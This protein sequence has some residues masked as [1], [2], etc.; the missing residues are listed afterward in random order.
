LEGALPVDELIA[1]AS[2][3]RDSPKATCI[4]AFEFASKAKPEIVDETVFLFVTRSLKEK[5]PRVKW[6]SAKVIGNTAH[7]FQNELHEAIQYLLQ[8][9][10]N[11]GTVVRWSAAFA[12]GEILKLKSNLNARLLPQILDIVERET[13][14]S[15]RKIYLD[16]IK[17]T[18]K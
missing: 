14:N 13:Q 1:F 7:L 9:T 5:A 18:G 2:R 16:A 11:E 15:I 10:E 17:K 4:E 12:L 3:A 6:E 8:N